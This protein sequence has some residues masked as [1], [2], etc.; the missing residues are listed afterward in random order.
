MAGLILE[1]KSREWRSCATK[2]DDYLKSLKD[3]QDAVQVKLRAECSLNDATVA[4][5][6]MLQTK[7]VS[8]IIL[9]SATKEFSEHGQ[10]TV[11][12]VSDRVEVHQLVTR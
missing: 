7:G 2:L 11:C 4:L 12:D 5:A 8:S 10:Y 6:M 9:D 3:L 1:R